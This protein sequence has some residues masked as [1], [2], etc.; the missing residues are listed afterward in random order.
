VRFRFL[1]PLQ[2]CTDGGWREVGGAKTRSLLAILLINANQS[3]PVERLI[4]ELWPAGP[5]ASANTLVRGY[6]LAVRR[7]IGDPDG[8][9]LTTHARG[10]RMCVQRDDVDAN[11]F[12]GLL[13]EG[14]AALTGGEPERASRVLREGLALWHGA[15][16]A[17]VPPTSTV[18]AHAGRLEESRLGAL[19]ARIEAELALLADPGAG[20]TGPTAAAG[21]IGELRELVALHPF[22][23]RFAGQLMRA[24]HAAGRRAEALD[25][26]A[27]ARRRLVDEL[28]L[29]PGSELQ[30]MHH[31]I[32]IAEP[33]PTPDT[34]PDTGPEPQGPPSPARAPALP[35]P[36]QT[37]PDIAD[38]TGRD[39]EARHCLD[40]LSRR[41]APALPVVVIS[42]RGGAGKSALAV[43]LAHRL[44]S[45]Y[46][47]G[48]LYADLSGDSA[49][50]A[51]P[52]RLLGQ[53]LR[54]LGV[55]AANVPK[56]G[57]ERA[58]LYRS[59][60]RD[61]RVLVVL[62]NAAGEAQVRPL[63]PGSSGCAV[64][65]TSRS[66]LAGLEGAS[67]VELDA[68]EPVD[69][70]DLFLKIVDAERVAGELDVA[71]EIVGLCGHLPLAVRVAAARVGGRPG[72]PLTRLAAALRDERR[73]LDELRI[74]DLEVRA[75]IAAS[76]RGLDDAQRRMFRL[77]GLLDAADFA[78]WTAAAVA[79][80]SRPRAEA[81]VGT[82][83]E[84]R[85]VDEAGTDEAGQL[86]YRLHDLVRLFARERAEAEEGA[87][88]RTAAL[89][90]ALGALLYVA[91][92]A[93]RRMPAH[94]LATV[95]R[96]LP[97]WPVEPDVVEDL[98]RDP[99]AWFESERAFLL[100]AITQAGRSGQYGLAS[101]LAA[102]AHTFYELRDL[103]DDG[104]QAHQVALAACRAAADGLGEAVLL[105]N[106]ADL[107]NSRP[108][109][110]ID[111]KLAYAESA[112]ALFRQFG[113][114]RGAAD[115]LYLCSDVHRVKGDPDRALACLEASREAA[116]SVGYRL[117]ER[118]V[119]LQLAILRR[120][121][122][123][124]D[125]AAAAAQRALAMARES[126]STRDESVALGILGVVYRELGDLDRSESSFQPAIEIARAAGDPLQEAYLSIHL[127][128]LYVRHQHPG[129]RRVLEH[130]LAL[131]R[132]LRSVF[133][134]A[135]ALHGLGELDRS[136]GQ[137]R[138]A[139]A[140]LAEAARLWDQLE[141]R[142]AQ[143]R[144]LAALGCA[145]AAVREPDAA[146]AARLAALELYR[147]LGNTDQVNEV[148]ARLAEPDGNRVPGAASV[149][150]GADNR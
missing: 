122:G 117:G 26:Y 105:R 120:E 52:V 116:T 99:F 107:H 51:E 60:L 31:D 15:P 9:L 20:P 73:R 115:A 89:G 94:T 18:V 136:V 34:G 35:T 144:T 81:L 10:Y 98:V 100:T 40:I 149:S 50:P 82:L 2:A 22:R 17:D 93:D 84:A 97:R 72:R 32:L 49:T 48:Q 46:P 43:H 87:R 139:I 24:L 30:R 76:Y 75:S 57:E 77:L 47:D 4:A 137:H 125:D 92:E 95:H 71:E 88:A 5:P 3:V 23:E 28:G 145:H 61:R 44:G 126:N 96:D 123:R 135:L 42:G 19:E 39:K 91:E 85:L 103:Y 54:A 146:R 119:Y 58:S 150:V 66:R 86:R 63:R 141:A 68:F 13:A 128:Q 134:H 37:P 143:A 41:E 33:T 6:V 69:S 113:E 142:F 65:I 90:R 70:L 38:F 64:V 8:A 112:L 83:V 104:V 131:S 55:P 7:L 111:D 21:L 127:G 106:L 109:A 80:V 11:R 133:G 53:F 130:G 121:Q 118:H 110:A 129:A 124:Y 56:S 62:D 25:T 108:G 148:L 74:G 67:F 114:R 132:D 102:A 147:Q 140:R 16:L 138:R 78:E 27:D 1:G 36:M 14:R 79:D 12:E 101:G 45:V 59:Q 29:D